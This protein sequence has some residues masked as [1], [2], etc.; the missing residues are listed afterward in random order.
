MLSL[1]ISPRVKEKLS[2]IHLGRLQASLIGMEIYRRDDNGW[3]NWKNIKH[4]MGRSDKE[5]T[6]RLILH[7]VRIG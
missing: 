2:G 7:L 4:A 6:R 5:R 1:K 3:L